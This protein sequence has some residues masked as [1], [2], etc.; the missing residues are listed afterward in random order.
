MSPSDV[1]VHFANLHLPF[2]GL[3]TSG[4]GML[5][6]RAYLEACMHQRGVMSKGTSHA[7][8]LLDLQAMLRSP[9]YARTTTA[10][11][12]LLLTKLNLPLPPHYGYKAL[13]LLVV[14]LA[15]RGLHATGVHI[16]WLR[17]A[18]SYVLDVLGPA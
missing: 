15:L 1:L 7:A 12:R 11:V 14:C 16:H 8:R 2:G 9:P 17:A 18:A 4:Q 10:A 5:H 13:C 6:G 3:G